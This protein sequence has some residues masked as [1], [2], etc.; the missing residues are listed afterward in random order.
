MAAGTEL[1][2]Y[3]D[4]YQTDF[5][6]TV[7]SVEKVTGKEEKWDVILDRTCFYP[8]GGGQPS[9]FGEIDGIRVEH[10]YKKDGD[11]FHRMVAAPDIKEVYCRIDWSHRYDYMQQHTGQHIISG[12]LY[13]SGYETISVHQGMSITTIEVDKSD[14][15]DEDLKLIED[16]SNRVISKNIGVCSEWV[17]DTELEGLSLRRQ[18]KVSGKIRIIRVGDY[19]QV[20][21]GGVH[22]KSTGEIE[23]VKYVSVEKIR[24]HARIGWK[25]GRRV[26][27]DYK[28]NVHPQSLRYNLY[29]LAC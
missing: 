14:I 17:N 25:I 1:L 12:A 29:R 7:L 19:D 13:E 23:C 18:S 11:I 24:G 26:L 10:V 15:P 16:L 9:D 20:A 5:T 27:D 6:A 21:C 2:Y 28:E 4:P 3:K 22:T 8:E